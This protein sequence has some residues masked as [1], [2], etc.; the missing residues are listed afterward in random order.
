MVNMAVFW[1]SVV[2][3]CAILGGAPAAPRPP[4]AL[5][6]KKVLFGD[7]SRA[8]LVAGINAVADAVKVTLGPKG[9]NVVLERAYGAPEIVNDGVTIA[10][11]IELEDPAMNIGAKLIQEVAGKSDSKAGDGTT[12]TTLMT[13]ELVNQGMK[14]VSSGTNPVAIRRGIAAATTALIA[15][16]EKLARPVEDNE[17]ILNIATIATSGNAAMGEVIAAAYEKVGD[18]GSTTLEESQTLTDEV[19]FTEG[20]T[21]DRGY[22]SPYFV[23]DQERQLCELRDPRILVT[24]AKIENVNDLIPLLE[25]MVKSKEPLVIIAEDVTAEALS[26]LVV[27]KMRGVLDVVAIKAPGF[28]TRRKD[29]LNDIAI[30]T[31][32]TYVAQEV[33]VALDTV[34]P[35]ML[36]TAERIVVGK[37]ETTIVTD[38]KQADAMAKRIDQIKVE[39]DAS[40]SAF[41]KEKATERVAALGGG[42]ARIKVGAATETELKDKKLRYEDALQAVKSALKTG[43]LP[44]GGSTFSYLLR[45][46]DDVTKSFDDEDERRGAEIVFN[47]LAA[48]ICQIAK[49]AG[50]EGMVVLSKVEGKEFG[51][52]YDAAAETYCDLFAGGV[53]D[54]AQV[55]LS[56]LENSASIAG[57]VLTTEALI[58]EIPVDQ[59]EAE[60]LAAMDAMAGMGGMEYM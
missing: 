50:L 21:V 41:D 57:L 12:T 35:D 48:P 6:A 25:G 1:A 39:A 3:A 54:S 33:G 53:V 14:A 7:A 30:A 18:T 19:E 32:A 40:E 37:E 59:S 4:S 31:G 55:T 36:G 8:Q 51:Y 44:G 46:R 29:L 34:T 26:A 23:N 2:P 58:H 17:A 42:I 38:G 13:Q 56:A 11:D 24:D 16:C 28:G 5:A 22:V 27:N 47:S 10:R 60:K 52:G 20:L 43:I 9:R 15:E 45:F 49:N